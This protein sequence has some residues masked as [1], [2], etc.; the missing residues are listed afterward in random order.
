M[1]VMSGSGSSGGG[2]RGGGCSGPFCAAI[3]SMGGTV[4]SNEGIFLFVC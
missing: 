2:G 3:A 4:P 1:A